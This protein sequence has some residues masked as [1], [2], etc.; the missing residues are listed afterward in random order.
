MNANQFSENFYL[1]K[2]TMRIIQNVYIFSSMYI[3]LFTE[4][5]QNII[6]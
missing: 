5:L 3:R 6:N 2:H 4:K 1:S